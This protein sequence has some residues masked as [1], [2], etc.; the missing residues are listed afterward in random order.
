MRKLIGIVIVAS[1]ISF[2]AMYAIW[3]SDHDVVPTPVASADRAATEDA[4]PDPS[5]S[6]PIRPREN[7]SE[8]AANRAKRD[9]LRSRIIA[10]REA[11]TETPRPANAN[12]KSPAV[13]PSDP[14]P[15]PASP[16]LDDRTGN[17]GYLMKVMN[18]DL[19]PLADECIAMAR[20]RQPDLAGMLII[21]LEL[22]GDEEVGGVVETIG[23]GAN[24]E[25]A[26]VDLLE[27]LTE[28][29]L[30]ATLPP[31]PEGGRDALSLSM[32]VADDE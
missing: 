3:R 24:N 11:D 10:A 32:P 27:C 16:G 31:P 17:H 14:D 12:Q 18:E 22:I 21:D 30:S 7:E 1:L 19:M 2:V 28:S 26:D 20:E 9:E 8:R 13:Q 29:I 4:K 6:P 5:T 15:E 25:V 23:P